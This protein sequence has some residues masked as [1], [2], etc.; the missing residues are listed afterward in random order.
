MSENLLEPVKG[1]VQ[2][3]PAGRRHHNANEDRL[4]LRELNPDDVI[5]HLAHDGNAIEA[6]SFGIVRETCPNCATS[7]LRLV[8]RQESVRIAHLFCVD[9]EG[10]FDACYA[11]G[12]PAL[13]I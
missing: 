12:T 1:T 2:P 6:V 9:C 13:T 7:H 8:L 11:N 4:I 10:C 3:F 5:D